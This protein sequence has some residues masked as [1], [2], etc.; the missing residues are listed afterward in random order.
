M[1]VVTS[2]WPVR[3]AGGPR[4]WPAQG[5]SGHGRPAKARRPARH[6][7]VTPKSSRWLPDRQ[8]LLAAP[9]SPSAGLLLLLGLSG[10]TLP[11]QSGD[12]HR[13]GDPGTADPLACTVVQ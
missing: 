12:A 4:P 5:H 10:F 11:T 3:V 13:L 2:A 1:V 7:G 8:S 6:P 9:H